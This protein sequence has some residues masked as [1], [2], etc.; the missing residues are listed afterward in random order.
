MPGPPL[1]CACLV[2]HHRR[3]YSQPRLSACPSCGEHRSEHGEQHLADVEGRIVVESPA[4][5]PL[6]VASA[7]SFS[8]SAPEPSNL[9]RRLLSIR[10][11]SAC[12]SRSAAGWRS[13]RKHGARVAADR[14]PRPALGVPRGWDQATLSLQ[15]KQ[16]GSVPGAEQDEGRKGPSLPAVSLSANSW[17]T[18]RVSRMKTLDFALVEDGQGVVVP[19]GADLSCRSTKQARE[20][21]DLDGRA[22]ASPGCDK[23]P[24]PGRG[25]RRGRCGPSPGCPRMFR[26][27][28]LVEQHSARP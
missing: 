19:P 24:A 13:T 16:A 18:A 7:S 4:L 21:L 8:I 27:K 3:S 25:S 6:A 5:P 12:P 2:E 10:F 9:R 11:P 22:N 26:L 15:V 1:R 28:Q 17:R 14:R 23:P 20:V